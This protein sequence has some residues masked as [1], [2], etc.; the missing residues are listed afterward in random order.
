MNH[1][2]AKNRRAFTLIELLVVIAIIGILSA[3]LLPVLSRA[4]DRA[5]QAQCLSNFKQDGVAL[6]MFVDEHED[7]LPPSGTNSLL[8]TERPMY[9]ST[10]IRLL[11]YYLAP[12]LSLPAP[13]NLGA[14][15]NV[16][17]TL[18]CPAYVRTL[19]GNTQ[20]GYD[21]YSDN[22]ARA[23]CFALSRQVGIV[24]SDTP[25]APLHAYP[26]GSQKLGEPSL[27]ISQLSQNMPLS[28]VWAV[29]DLDQ[30]AIADPTSLGDGVQEYVALAPPHKTLRNFLY[31][32][33][34]AASKPV[35]DWQ[36]Y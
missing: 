11:G 20:A 7:Q 12:Y 19:P 4:R 24:D 1:D 16:A 10:S 33:M 26:F 2:A 6:Q 32:D 5:V 3:L 36:D 31:F 17:K 18:L 9:T 35:T 28:E 34:H 25:L 15:T 8:L 14:Q 22:F 21:G 13:Q 23:Y 29:A 27:K 30:E